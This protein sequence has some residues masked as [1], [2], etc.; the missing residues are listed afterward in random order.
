M[1]ERIKHSGSHTEF[2]VLCLSGEHERV[3]EEKPFVPPVHY[4]RDDGVECCA[5]TIPVGP[6]SCPACRE[7]HGD[8]KATPRRPAPPLP[9]PFRVDTH[10]CWEPLHPHRRGTVRITGTR[11]D[12]EAWWIE[13]EALGQSGRS[14]EGRRRWDD[15]DRFIE[16]AVAVDDPVE[17]RP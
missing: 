4:R 2:C 5:H 9:S 11:W 8:E 6:D 13:T 10:W 1:T 15:L 17:W 16:S 3:D 14:L 7:L 12:G